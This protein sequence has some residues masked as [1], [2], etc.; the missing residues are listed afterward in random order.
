MALAVME[1]PLP[2]GTSI[3]LL[4]TIV[5]RRARVYEHLLPTQ[6]SQTVL[7]HKSDQAQSDTRNDVKRR[8][9]R[10]KEILPQEITADPLLFEA[11]DGVLSIVFWVSL[12]RD[13][14]LSAKRA[15]DV[16]LHAVLRL[17]QQS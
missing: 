10:L 13:Q 2:R 17:T 12:R 15:K 5:E 3:E 4:H 1:E 16:M 14:K 6:I 8:R 11:I 9:K 7:F